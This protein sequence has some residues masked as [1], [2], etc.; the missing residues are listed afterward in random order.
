M[1]RST[2]K[3]V[4]S[5]SKLGRSSSKS[6]MA[7]S[8]SKMMAR[9]SSMLVTQVRSIRHLGRTSVKFRV[10]LRLERVEKIAGK[11]SC[12]FVMEKPGATGTSSSSVSTPGVAIESSA[13]VAD[14]TG[15]CPLVVEVTLFKKKA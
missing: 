4:K 3:L 6:K 12:V 8:S 9:S 5:T 13:G 14:F 11:G 10:E 2:S 7:R 15:V 1:M